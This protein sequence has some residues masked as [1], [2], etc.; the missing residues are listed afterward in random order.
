MLRVGV[1]DKAS[2]KNSKQLITEVTLTSFVPIVKRKNAEKSEPAHL[3]SIQEYPP[4]SQSSEIPLNAQTLLIDA[5]L[6]EKWR[7]ENTGT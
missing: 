4:T 2:G 7:H 1:R 6:K 5:E 3:E